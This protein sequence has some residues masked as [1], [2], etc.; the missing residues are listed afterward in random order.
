MAALGYSIK[1]KR[2]L[3]LT[4]GAHFLHVFLYKCSLF[5]TLS[6][7]KVSTSYLSY[8]KFLVRQLMT[9]ETLRLSSIIP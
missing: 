1:L 2:G 3:E 7:E 8:I 5:N 6:T 9:S 4:G